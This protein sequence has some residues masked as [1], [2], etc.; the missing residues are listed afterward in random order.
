V[1]RNKKGRNKKV[2]IG[3]ATAKWGCMDNGFIQTK[4]G[5]QAGSTYR[6][7]K[8]R[9]GTRGLTG[10]E[11]AE[12]MG[13]KGD[14][15]EGK[16]QQVLG[17]VWTCSRTGGGGRVVCTYLISKEKKKP[18]KKELSNREKPRENEKKFKEP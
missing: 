2:K 11:H 16:G 1:K 9:T 3:R 13:T 10:H 14:P 8:R 6:K 15:I 7:K 18:K 5:T 4:G 12:K 17:G